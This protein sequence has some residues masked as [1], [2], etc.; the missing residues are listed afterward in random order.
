MRSREKQNNLISIIFTGE[1]EASSTRRFEGNKVLKVVKVLK[2]DKR[3]ISARNQ[4]SINR[5]PIKSLKENP[6][7]KPIALHMFEQTRIGET[8]SQLERHIFDGIEICWQ[9]EG[10][11]RGLMNSNADKTLKNVHEVNALRTQLYDLAKFSLTRFEKFEEKCSDDI[12]FGEDQ[13]VEMLDVN[14]LSKSNQSIS[15]VKIIPATLN[16]RLSKDSIDGTNEPIKLD[17]RVIEDKKRHEFDSSS[18]ES[19]S[20]CD[21]IEMLDENPNFRTK[22]R[23]LDD[24]LKVNA[25]DKI[26]CNS[27]TP[28][29]IYLFCF[30]SSSPCPLSTTDKQ[31][32]LK[33]AL[34][35]AIGAL[36][37]SDVESDISEIK[38]EDELDLDEQIFYSIFCS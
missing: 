33:L 19:G 1:I 8:Q 5:H 9:I 26:D 35:T 22:R 38:T 14:Q 11:L 27:K 17:S 16:N 21:V 3:V 31:D 30:Q 2:V 13:N 28:D 34:K 12:E 20:S 18:D 25:T 15:M 23:R 4:S 6:H 24:T 7:K 29:D 37:D 32:V 36:A 10:K